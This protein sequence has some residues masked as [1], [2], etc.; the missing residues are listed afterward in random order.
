[1]ETSAAILAAET[2]T[3]KSSAWG[4][5]TS[6][7]TTATTKSRT[8]AVAPSAPFGGWISLERHHCAFKVQQVAEKMI[9]LSSCLCRKGK[10][11]AEPKGSESLWIQHWKEPPFYLFQGGV[12]LD[13]AWAGRRISFYCVHGLGVVDRSSSPVYQTLTLPISTPFQ[14]RG[15]ERRQ[16]WWRALII[17]DVFSD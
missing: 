9:K 4:K 10:M 16:L 14:C 12:G 5:T 3:A 11:H 8:G 15:I 7:S 6:T 17:Q 13:F 2:T 1:M